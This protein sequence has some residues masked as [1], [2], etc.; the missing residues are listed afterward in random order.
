VP[1]DD[2]NRANETPLA[3]PWLLSTGSGGTANLV[4]NHVRAAASGPDKFYYYSGAAV[5]TEQFS[6]V[7]IGDSV[8]DG[9]PAVRIS[10]V[11][12]VGPSGYWVSC[13]NSVLNFLVN[14]SLSSEGAIGKTIADGDTVR[15]TAEGNELNVY[16][17][18]ILTPNSP[19]FD[20]SLPL[21][22][23]GVGFFYFEPLTGDF[24]DDF[25]GGDLGA[26]L[27]WITA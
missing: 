11:A 17:N 15:L 6:Q 5:S 14:G 13:F 9:G 27:A 8:M 2:F 24:I 18:G 20:S 25:V 21:A 10:G 26:T 4:S 3:S 12:G 22:G 19:F 7:T 1:S 23:Q 16:V